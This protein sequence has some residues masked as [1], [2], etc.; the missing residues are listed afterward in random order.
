MRGG[1]DID[2]KGRGDYIMRREGEER[3]EEEGRLTR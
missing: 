2:G 1:E 3:W